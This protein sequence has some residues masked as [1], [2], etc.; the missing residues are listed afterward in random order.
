VDDLVEY[1]TRLNYIL[2]KY[3]IPF[4]EST[5]SPSLAQTSS[6]TSSH[7]PHGRDRRRFAGETPSSF[8][9]MNS[10]VSY[11]HGGNGNDPERSSSSLEPQNHVVALRGIRDS[12]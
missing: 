8:H 4:S 2:P 3:P 6:W 1:E 5:I 7:S 11:A 12:S 10:C 9:P